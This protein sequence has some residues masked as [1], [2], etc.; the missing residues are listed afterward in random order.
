MLVRRL[1]DNRLAVKFKISLSEKYGLQHKQVNSLNIY[2][3]II[4]KESIE[5]DNTVG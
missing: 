1:P 2:I 4:R 3:I 5:D